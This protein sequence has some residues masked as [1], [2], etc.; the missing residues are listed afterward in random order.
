VGERIAKAGDIERGRN[1]CRPNGALTC[2]LAAL[3]IQRLDAYAYLYFIVFTVGSFDTNP[4]PL[5]AVNAQ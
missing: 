1:I 2:K 4:K 3:S 5:F